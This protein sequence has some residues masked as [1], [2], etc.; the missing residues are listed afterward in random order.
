M[1]KRAFRSQFVQRIGRL[2]RSPGGR[3][4]AAGTS[5]I[6]VASMVGWVS[7][8]ASAAPVARTPAEPADAGPLERPDE[9]AAVI[10]ARLTGKRVLITGRTTETEQAWALPSGAIEVEAS[11]GPVRTRAA[12]G[13]WTAVDVN[14]VRAADGSVAPKAH[15]Y[16]LTLSGAAG[17]GEHTLVT[18]GKAGERSMLGWTG[19]L[20]EPVLTGPK[21][22]YAEVLPGVDLVVTATRTGYE[23]FLVVKNRAAATQ[24]TNVRLPWK[25]EGVTTKADGAGGLSLRSAA[26]AEVSAVPAPIM[27]DAT[28]DAASGENVRRAPVGMAVD[29]QGLVLTPDQTFLAD[30]KTTY[31]VTIDPSQTIGASFDAFVQTGYSSDQSGAT[32]LKLG[33]YDGGANVA[34]SFLTFGGLTWLPNAQIQSATL[35][36]YNQHSWSCDAAS[37]EA[38]WV[39]PVS[40]ATRWT[41]QPAWNAKIGTSTQTKGYNSTCGDGWVTVPVATAF[42]KAADARANNTT[43]GIR[44]TSE[45]ANAGW[46]RFNSREAA[47]NPP[48]VTVVY[49]SRPVTTAQATVP[50]TSCV[51][52][53]ARPY[54]NS[55][56]PQLRA[57]VTDGEGAA[58]TA[59]FEWWVTGGS[60]PLGSATVGPGASGSW[61]AAPVAAGAFTENGTYSWKVRGSDGTVDGP[62]SAWCEF[63]VDTVEPS[64]QPTVAS[65]A[66]PSGVWSGGAGTGGSFTFGASGVSD[67]VAYEYGL[68]ANPPDQTVTAPGAGANATVTITPTTD[69][70]Q[71]LFV[72]SRDRAGNQSA[73]RAYPFA[74]GGGAVVGPKDGH[75]T[76][77]K[78]VLSALGQGSATGVTYQWRRADA[79]AWTNIPTGHVTVSAGGGAVTW[80]LP[81]T[82]SGA[83]ANLNWDVAATLAAVDAVAVP[84]DGPLQVRAVFTGGSNPSSTPV[85]FTFDRNLA[86]AE[87]EEIGPG[88]VNL[89]TGNMTIQDTDVSVDSYGTDLT[90]V[91]SYNTRLAQT[92]DAATMFGPGW[93]SGAIVEEADTPYTSLTRY[94]SLV[95]VGLPEGET[96]GFTKLTT[97]EFDPEPGMEF[98]KLVYNTT[99]DSYS[100]SDVDGNTVVFTRVANT[101]VG[102][103]F[104]TSVTVP[105]NAQT[106]TL[107][108]EKVTVDGKEVV[109]PTRMVAPVADGVNCATLTRGCRALTFKYATATSATGTEQVGWGSYAGRVQEISLVAWDPDAAT[110][111]MRVVP[112]VKYLYDGTGR[113]RA[114]WDP[115]LDYTADGADRHQWE[116]YDYDAAGVLSTIRPAGEEPWQLTYTTVP[117]DPGAG[118][119]HKVTRSAL[120][121]GT[122][123][124]TV[125]Y[126]VPTAGT[127]APYDLSPG[128]TVR[129]GQPEAPTDATAIF[130]A[131]QV[132]TGNPATGTLPSSYTR[133][134]VTYLDA[135]GQETN[136]AAPGGHISATWRDRFNNV[137]RTL[138]AGNRAAALGASPTDDAKTETE[139]AFDLSSRSVYSDDG[140][141]LSFTMDP[142]HDVML[143]NGSTVRGRKVTR[144]TY[145]Q[146]APTTGAPYNLVTTEETLVWY[147]AANGVEAEADVRRSTTAYDWTLR[148][149]V[150]STVDPGGLNLTTRTTHDPVSGQ[151]ATL[152][153]PAGGTSTNTPATRRTIYYRAT[154]GSGAA[155][156]DLR[157]EWANLV[158]RIEPGGQA[159]SG[160]ELPVTV[161]TYDIYNNDRTVTEKTSAGVQRTTTT[162]YDAA[163]REYESSVTVAAGLGTAVPVERKVY[164]PATGNLLRTQSIVAGL[165]A[166][167]LRSTYDTLGRQT[168]YTDADGNVSTTTYDLLGRV[169]TSSDGKATRTVTYDGG[170]ERR[171]LATSVHD[172][173]VGTFTAAYDADGAAVTTTW[174]NGIVVTNDLDETGAAVGVTYAQ[175]NCGATDCTLFKE[176]VVES[177]HGQWRR[178]SSTL[179][180]RVYGYDAGGRLT[181]VRDSAGEQCT[182]RTYGVDAAADRRT[183]AEY[184]AAA[185]GSCQTATATA[186]TSLTYDTANR[187]GLAGYDRLGRTTIVPAA[188]TAVPAAGDIAVTYHA[189][190]LVDT[191]TQ[192]GRTT[193]YTL[194]VT[195]E[196]VRSWTDNGVQRTHHYDDDGDNPAWTQESADSYTRVVSGVSGMAAIW[197][198]AG[199]APEWQITNLHGDVVATIHHGDAG[200]STTGESTE[201]GLPNGSDTVGA[202]RYGWLGGKQR[203]ADAPAGIVLMGVRLYNPATGR[204]LQVDPVFGGSCNAYEYT[205][206]DPVNSEDLDGKWI[207][208]VLRGAAAA[209]KL[210]KRWCVRA[211]KWVGKQAWRGIKWG[212]KHAWRGIKWGG[213]KAWGGIKKGASWA[214]GK[215]SW[216]FGRA[217]Y[218]RKGILNRGPVR[219]GWT[220]NAKQQR[221]R[222]GIHTGWPKHKQTNWFKRKFPRVHWDWF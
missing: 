154:S 208:L 23:Q 155:E 84:R 61:L 49:Q 103:Y 167:E 175:P 85:R 127:G 165:V 192:Q 180:N 88:S 181:S 135:N 204:F 78:T 28:V 40:S 83:F 29:K 152:T 86:A 93:V 15:P 156:C 212:G 166:A 89:L 211:G 205:C 90:V 95:Q 22:T 193:D 73:V 87:G 2:I 57:R 64:A 174:P 203:A 110:P 150:V 200:L 144:Y 8:P 70:P 151:A 118:R 65:T 44:A 4:F 113:L 106:T 149:P 59:T 50:S 82:G 68:N 195:G 179:S 185:D 12:D 132:P 126:R 176:S 169:A 164:D 34:R 129:W 17:P 92:T 178:Q 222:F 115:R 139:R 35:S 190:D 77:E 109:R 216:L 100:L 98:L 121:A 168:S 191:I 147:R 42:Q 1:G 14:L 187:I 158:C 213:R 221:N 10:T 27:W 75:I 173:H 16:G 189:S 160:P 123:T 55:K 146:G 32:E 141:R 143:D 107:S 219:L 9:K 38:W 197:D 188:Q 136:T 6:L 130:P 217:K 96:I 11:A 62:W 74:V 94:D 48:Q 125:V 128:Q 114:T 196:R 172:S 54:I 170:T 131:D 69:G 112:M 81:T 45:T 102:K 47:S 21:A 202:V 13:S 134:V 215:K 138:S 148:E 184:A 18:L 199:G 163:G 97:T 171:G 207:G 56:T 43:V 198:S 120:A 177:V 58:V 51:T 105:G 116:T 19:R 108:W 3:V 66:Y 53:T 71:T 159:A 5:T 182:T 25:T 145:D 24:V 194:D 67:V 26:G 183:L 79:D 153:G 60:A 119:L 122:A 220:W 80:P 39:G 214:F 157:P 99:N 124:T 140:R 36:L 30:E 91:R 72:R 33:T 31:P 20:P 117:N 63:T 104:P 46:K 41:N 7:A 137:T 76:A 101:A 142:V 210:G 162:T 206:A 218:G 133:A 201:Y 209:C 186:T 52:G 111:G 161:T 37:W